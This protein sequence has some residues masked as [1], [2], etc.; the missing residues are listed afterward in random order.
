MYTE[1]FALSSQQLGMVIIECRFALCGCFP[2]YCLKCQ[3]A[4][5]ALNRLF[6][7]NFQIYIERVG[8]NKVDSIGIR[9]L[10]LVS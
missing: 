3:L 9:L 10:D 5:T 6:V 2:I 1:T 4:L 7:L 8:R